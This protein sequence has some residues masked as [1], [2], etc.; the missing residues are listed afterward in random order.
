MKELTRGGIKKS[1]AAPFLATRAMMMKELL[2]VF[3]CPLFG[4]EL[5]HDMRD[6]WSGEDHLK[7]TLLRDVIPVVEI[8]IK[9][10]VSASALFDLEIEFPRNLAPAVFPVAKTCLGD[11]CGQRTIIITMLATG[12]GEANIERFVALPETDG[13]IRHIRKLPRRFFGE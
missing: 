8:G 13:K 4:A 12:T 9:I 2:L 5:K 1:P 11:R 10:P 3:R 6:H 7:P